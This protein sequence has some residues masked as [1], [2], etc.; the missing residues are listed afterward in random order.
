MI[1]ANACQRKPSRSVER[2]KRIAAVLLMFVAWLGSA[3]ESAT[4]FQLGGGNSKLEWSLKRPVDGTEYPKGTRVVGVVG[5]KPSGYAADIRVEDPKGNISHLFIPAIR[6]YFFSTISAGGFE[7]KEG[8]W[9]VTLT[10][11][12]DPDVAK[13]QTSFIVL[14]GEADGPFPTI[15]VPREGDR[16]PENIPY[17]VFSGAANDGN[18]VFLKLIDR[19]TGYMKFVA[20]VTTVD[21]NCWGYLHAWTY[22]KGKWTA[23]VYAADPFFGGVPSDRTNFETISRFEERWPDIEAST[24]IPDE[25]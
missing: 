3:Q 7:L 2:G 14:E 1:S 17:I 5:F 24:Q 21:N 20:R 13:D 9:E 8:E 12:L 22:G 4:A 23:E 19:K 6:P 16:Y 11:A 18:E 10:N 25:D 15:E